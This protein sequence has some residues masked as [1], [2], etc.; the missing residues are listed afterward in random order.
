LPLVLFLGFR[1]D[2]YNSISIFNS[3]RQLGYVLARFK[4]LGVRG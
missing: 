3:Q 2:E 4:V 1:N